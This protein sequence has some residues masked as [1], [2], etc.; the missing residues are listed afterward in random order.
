MV[1]VTCCYRRSD[2]RPNQIRLRYQLRWQSGR[3]RFLWSERIPTFPFPLLSTLRGKRDLPQACGPRE[4][5][6]LG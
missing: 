6:C 3:L 1:A 2:R 5:E 4:T